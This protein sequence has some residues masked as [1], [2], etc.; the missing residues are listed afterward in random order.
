MNRLKFRLAL[1]LISASVLLLF[2]HVSA[3]GQESE[4]P[5]E[6][7]P[8]PPTNVVISDHPNDDG[9]TIEVGWELS[10]DDGAGLN[11][12]MAYEIYRSTSAQ[13]EFQQVG[14]M[15]KGLNTYTD[16]GEK[17]KTKNGEPNPRYIGAGIDYYYKMRTKTTAGTYSEFSEVVSGQA[18]NNWY[19]TGKTNI[20]VAVL[21]F[22]GLVVYF[23]NAA[24]KGKELYVRPIAGINAVDE[25]I[26]R[27]TEMGR[28]ILF[29]LGTGTAADLATIAGYTILARVAKMTA[30]YQ[31]RVLVPV[32]EPVMLAVAQETVR[33]AYMEAGRPDMYDEKNIFYV[34][35][36]Q[37]PFVAAVCGIMLREETA[38]NFYMGVFHAESLILA[39][40][41]A[42]S[43]AIQISG[44]DQIAQLPFFVAATDYT[45]IGEELYA[46]SGYLSKEALLLGPIKAQDYTKAILVALLGLAVI[47]WSFGWG[48]F[49]SLISTIS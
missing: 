13:G 25:S 45:L 21:V 39:E 14:V 10:K 33:N 48:F 18:Q 11:N 32:N 29:V 22:G 12:V 3:L 36:M 28:P 2:S 4:R 7:I 20:L 40:T 44:T 30:D 26:G 16:R 9:H 17:D 19:H 1:V 42:I 35:A 6:P 41:G 31:T 43:G 23:I 37:F 15:G 27:A 46:A 24:R 8:A 5:A 34:T 38:T 49:K 47:T